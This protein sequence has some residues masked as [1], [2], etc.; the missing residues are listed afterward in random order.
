MN[1]CLGIGPGLNIY[2]TIN[3][4]INSQFNNQFIIQS[5]QQS[6]LALF[7]SCVVGHAGSYFPKQ[8]SNLP[9]LGLPAPCIGSTESSSLYCQACLD[10][11]FF[12]GKDCLASP[13]SSWG[14]S[15]SER[16]P[17]DIKWLKVVGCCCRYRRIGCRHLVVQDR[18]CVCSFS[19]PSSFHILITSVT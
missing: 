11:M 1:V 3:Q 17:V 10:C 18:D 16:N 12:E 7:F 4:F 5:T 8:G 13:G 6:L 15:C 9:A 19:K 14:L 2:Y